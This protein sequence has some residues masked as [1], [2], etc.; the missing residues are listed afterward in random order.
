VVKVEICPKLEEK[1]CSAGKVSKSLFLRMCVGNHES[2]YV[3]QEKKTPLEW[4]KEMETK[5]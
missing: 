2:C 1:T 3:F 5:K 4:L